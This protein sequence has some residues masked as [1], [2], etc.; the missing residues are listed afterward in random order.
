MGRSME[1]HEKAYL[2]GIIDGEGSISI[3]RSGKNRGCNASRL[4]L[5]LTI[6]STSKNLLEYC[7]AV[8]EGGQITMKRKVTSNHRA[9]Y[10]WRIRNHNAGRI[11]FLIIPY[12]LLKKDQALL[13]I[14]FVETIRPR[15]GSI[16]LSV[17]IQVYR[18]DCRSEIMKMNRKRESEATPDPQ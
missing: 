7:K 4:M 16:P 17:E 15:G 2:A 18:E 13:A 1:V 11:L 12:L 8:T 9:C 10:E 5:V 14:K 6:T 3:S